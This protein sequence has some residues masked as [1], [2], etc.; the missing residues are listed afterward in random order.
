MLINGDG[1]VLDAKALACSG[2]HNNPFGSLISCFLHLTMLLAGFV[3]GTAHTHSLSLSYSLSYSM[4]SLSFER[5]SLWLCLI[6]LPTARESSSSPSSA[7]HW[8]LW[9]VDLK[10]L[11]SLQDRGDAHFGIEWLHDRMHQFSFEYLL[12]KPTAFLPSS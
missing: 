7:F 2:L 6:V 4:F 8:Q 10:A 11:I 3:K 12:Q 5:N 1:I 9:H